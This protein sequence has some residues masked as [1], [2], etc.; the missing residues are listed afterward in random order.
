MVHV[1]PRLPATVWILI[2]PDAPT[3]CIDWW[4][5]SN[6]RTEVCHKLTR[7][8]SCEVWWDTWDMRQPPNNDLPAPTVPLITPSHIPAAP[9]LPVSILSICNNKTGSSYTFYW[10][11]WLVPFIAVAVLRWYWT[12]DLSDVTSREIWDNNSPGWYHLLSYFTPLCLGMYL[13][14]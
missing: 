5:S 1:S 12:D 11:V 8:D 3:V 10:R 2:G 6:E 7:T 14:F 4:G 13:E 9:A